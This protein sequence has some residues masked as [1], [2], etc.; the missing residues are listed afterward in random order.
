MPAAWAEYSDQKA[1]AEA[2][3]QEDN[4]PVF[5]STQFNHQPGDVGVAFDNI[6]TQDGA[7][8]VAIQQ[9]QKKEAS[10]LTAMLEDRQHQLA[11]Q[12][13]SVEKSCCCS[14]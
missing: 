3:N 14:E 9:K 7:M 4:Q 13:P 1:K 2:S 6:G 8:G 10:E 11:G 5:G 12:V